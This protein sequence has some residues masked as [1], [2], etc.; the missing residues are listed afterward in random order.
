MV[1]EN[2]EDKL[3]YLI[4]NHEGAVLASDGELKNS[5]HT[6]TVITNVLRLVDSIPPHTH[7]YNQ[8]TITY[9]EHCYIISLSNKKIYI[10]KRQFNIPKG[11]VL[12]ETNSSVVSTNISEDEEVRDGDTSSVAS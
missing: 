4:L 12:S 9:P 2:V 8:L 1:F 10:L 11:A 5:E 7:G 6:A 3:G